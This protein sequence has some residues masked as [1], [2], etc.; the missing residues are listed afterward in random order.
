VGWKIRLEQVPQIGF[1]YTA[2]VLLLDG[3]VE[4][5]CLSFSNAHFSQMFKSLTRR[6]REAESG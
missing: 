4:D 6:L 1:D 3:N 2:V 5:I